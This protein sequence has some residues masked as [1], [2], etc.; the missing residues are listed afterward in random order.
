[1]EDSLLG[2]GSSRRLESMVFVGIMAAVRQATCW[3]SSE[4]PHLIPKQEHANTPQGL[5]SNKATPHDPKPPPTGDQAFK[6][7]NRL[8]PFFLFFNFLLVLCEF[9]SC[10]S[11]PLHSLSI[12]SHPSNLATPQ[13]KQNND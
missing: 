13:R 1:M 6:H 5:A 12:L 10:I 9:T 8:E 3:G 7:M 4:N 2:S 11:I